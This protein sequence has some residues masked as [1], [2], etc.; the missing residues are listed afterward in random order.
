MFQYVSKTRTGVEDFQKLSV[1]R[2]FV[3]S[4]NCIF[5]RKDR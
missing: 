4:A 2:P 1:I 3:S 5:D